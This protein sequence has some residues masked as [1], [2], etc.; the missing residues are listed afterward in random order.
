MSVAFYGLYFSWKQIVFSVFI[1]V[2]WQGLYILF[3]LANLEYSATLRKPSNSYGKFHFLQPFNDRSVS[4]GE[5][6]KWWGLKPITYPGYRYYLHVG[7]SG[8]M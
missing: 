1:S 2:T 6:R 8:A 4:G 3:V 5:Q 7:L